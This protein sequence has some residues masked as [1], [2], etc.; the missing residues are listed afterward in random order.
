MRART[1]P[2]LGLLTSSLGLGGCGANAPAGGTP[3]T[4]APP[5][6]SLS[7]FG[8]AQ[9]R[10]AVASD[11]LPYIRDQFTYS[12]FIGLYFQYDDAGVLVAPTPAY[13]AASQA[14]E[15]TSVMLGKYVWF[16]PVEERQRLFQLLKSTAGYEFIDV[17]VIVDEPYLGGFTPAQFQ[18][19]VLEGKQSFPGKQYAVNFSPLEFTGAFQGPDGPMYDEM[20]DY[21]SFDMY[22]A[23]FDVPCTSEGSWKQKIKEDVDFF[24]A[25]TTKPLIYVAQGFSNARCPLTADMV[26]WTYEVADAEGLYGLVFW[27]SEK[28]GGPLTGFTSTPPAEQR[29]RELGGRVVRRGEAPQ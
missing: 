19:I 27:F 18:A 22:P 10:G 20:L 25:R 15:T 6:S 24:R 5:S 2:L 26:D 8:V 29:V 4:P 7:Y 21:I 3:P 13:L 28:L 1:L 9:Y 23:I 16:L 11:Y 14:F 17:I 12:N